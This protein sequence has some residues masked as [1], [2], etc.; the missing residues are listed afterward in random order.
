MFS[1]AL[2]AQHSSSD[3]FRWDD[4]SSTEC[5]VYAY[6]YFENRSP[7]LAQFLQV[8]SAASGELVARL[9][10]QLFRGVLY[11]AR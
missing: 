6:N 5:V 10:T 2:G 11:E 4:L 8:L 9:S 3:L 7:V 1:F